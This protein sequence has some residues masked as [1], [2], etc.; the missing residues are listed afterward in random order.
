MKKIVLRSLTLAAVLAGFMSNSAF[1]DDSAAMQ[2]SAADSSKFTPTMYISISYA[3][4]DSTRKTSLDFMSQY[5]Y[6]GGQFT[7]GALTAV[8]QV[9]FYG[10]SYGQSSISNSPSSTG[11]GVGIRQAYVGYDVYKND[12]NGTLN[13]K[14][15]RFIPQGAKAYGSDAQAYW[16]GMSGYFPED[17]VMLGYEGK[18]ANI[19]L[20]A[21]LSVV[22]GMQLYLYS[23]SG[24][25]SYGHPANANAWTFDMAGPIAAFA[26]SSNF[27]RNS[28]GDFGPGAASSNTSDKAYIASVSG[29]MDAGRNG[30]VEAVLTYGLKNNSI[31]NTVVNANTAGT[32]SSIIAN[33]VQYTEDSVGYDYKDGQLK[34]GLW[35]SRASLGDNK[36]M[37]D[38]N[39]GATSFTE[40]SS[41]PKNDYSVVGFGAQGNSALFGMTNVF[42]QG[43][44]LTYAAGVSGY[45]HRQSGT[46]AMSD[47]NAA[48]NDVTMLSLAGGFTKGKLSTE[49]NYSHFMASND[50]FLNRGENNLT[51]AADVV[52]LAAAINL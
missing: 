50:V 6:L 41:T 51:N 13:V 29:S 3:L 9:A 7:D 43:G 34:A 45:M 32:R 40:D 26:G 36:T 27:N 15:G 18:L 35:Y 12:S 1:A 19:D 23:D 22:N 8:G 21:Q 30:K 47:S 11:Q 2:G 42:T 31:A 46:G 17:G 20:N 49:L 38:T 37:S 25:A 33:D 44:M 4:I 10:N 52:Y 39:G 5:L 14:L 16:Y 48:K 28:G 24:V